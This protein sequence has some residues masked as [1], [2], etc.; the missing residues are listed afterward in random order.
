V[1]AAGL[2]ELTDNNTPG[3]GAAAASVRSPGVTSCARPPGDAW[4]PGKTRSNGPVRLP[5]TTAWRADPVRETR[6][7][8]ED[9]VLFNV[10]HN[11]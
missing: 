8:Q 3:G 11:S 1:F 6:D 7:E 2:S 5:P 4:F 9:V 10:T